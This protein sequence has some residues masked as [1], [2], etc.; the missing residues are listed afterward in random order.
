MEKA[1]K[2]GEISMP[3]YNSCRKHRTCMHN[4][5][6]AT[7]QVAV[8]SFS[9]QCTVAIAARP[10]VLCHA[11]YCWAVNLKMLL[12]CLLVLSAAL[13]VCNTQPCPVTG[14]SGC[15]T[16]TVNC[17]YATLNS[18]PELPLEVQQSVETL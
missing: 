9:Y 11:G 4:H 15:A 12:C 13:Q 14:C 8:A 3:E 7:A 2:G 1:K 16:T 5:D 6:F 18:F 10:H 17:S